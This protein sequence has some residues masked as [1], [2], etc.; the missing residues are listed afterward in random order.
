ML[1]CKTAAVVLK[2]T[3]QRGAVE[4]LMPRWIIKGKSDAKA[5]G[6]PFQYFQGKNCT[7]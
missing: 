7:S 3:K 5:L 6:L 2:K 4:G 1:C